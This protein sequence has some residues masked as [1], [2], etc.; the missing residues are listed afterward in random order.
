MGILIPTTNKS[1]Q[2]YHQGIAAYCPLNYI[3][4]A[5]GSGIVFPRGRFDYTVNGAVTS[6]EGDRGRYINFTGTT[7]V[8]AEI[9]QLGKG[10]VFADLFRF[11][12]C[13]LTMKIILNSMASV[14]TLFSCFNNVNA[15]NYYELR[16]DNGAQKLGIVIFNGAGAN[17]SA[18]HDTVLSTATEYNLWVWKSSNQWFITIDNNVADGGISYAQRANTTTPFR[19]GTA[20]SGSRNANVSIGHMVLWSRTLSASERAAYNSATSLLV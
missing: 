11:T 4:E 1:L 5:K 6:V 17:T 7:G 2:S 12:N 20:I 9:S 19:L 16:L 18:F 8:N 15:E 14:Q 13:T 10:S 3:D